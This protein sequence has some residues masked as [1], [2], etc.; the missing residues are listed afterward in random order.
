MN[1]NITKDGT[2]MVNKHLKSWP[3]SLTNIDAKILNKRMAN[4]LERSYT[5]TKSASSQGCRD[6]STYTNH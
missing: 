4:I 3:I 1:R 6:G 5:M 2:M